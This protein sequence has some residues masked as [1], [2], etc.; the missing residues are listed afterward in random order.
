VHKGHKR[1]GNS[2]NRFIASPLSSLTIAYGLMLKERAT[3]YSLNEIF[4][5]GLIL[6]A[7]FLR[8]TG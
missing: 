3:S 6:F 8:V 1:Q 4:F 5:R 7:R 2:L